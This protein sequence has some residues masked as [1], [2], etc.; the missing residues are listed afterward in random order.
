VNGGYPANTNR[1]FYLFASNAILDGFSIINGFINLNSDNTAGGGILNNGTVK[2]CII[3][4]NIVTGGNGGG[5]Y[6]GLVQ[7]CTIF[8]NSAASGGG[9]CEAT[10][11]QNCIISNNTATSHG[12]GIYGGT[13]IVSNCTVSGN[14]AGYG[15]G[16]VCAAMVQNCTIS[17]NS[18]TVV[19]GGV[20]GGTVQNSLVVGNSAG[21]GGGL[22]IYGGFVRNCII[23]SNSATISAGGVYCSGFIVFE[24]CTIIRNSAG[25]QYGGVQGGCG[26]NSIIYF[27]NCSTTSN[28]DG[29]ATNC[30]ISPLPSG[31]WGTN[32][33]ADDPQFVD[34]DA[35]DFRLKSASPC[36]NTGTNQSWMTN[37]MDI[38]GQPRIIDHIVDMGAYEYP[39]VRPSQPDNVS[40]SDGTYT[41]QVLIT[42][43]QSS[44]ALSYEV[45]RN[46]T[47]VIST[48]SKIGETSDINYSDTTAYGNQVYF[49]WVRAT[50]NSEVSA[51]S[52]YDSGWLKMF[53]P[54]VKANGSQEPVIV[55]LGDAVTVTVQMDPGDQIGLLKDWWVVAIVPGG[56]IYYF[57]SEFEWTP[58]IDLSAIHPVYQGGL[59]NLNP[60][61]VL[62]SITWLPTGSYTF[63]FAVDA[64][65]S[66]LNL[67]NIWVDSVELE[68]R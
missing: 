24:N 68:I 54:D 52:S 2:N 11:V 20:Q 37:A 31:S 46:L 60:Y 23:V 62:D 10:R 30:C 66:V 47:N 9:V 1:C 28:F 22:G 39:Y 53:G 55:N 51:F 43:S 42:W 41:N 13:V 3:T 58:A 67:D 32:N 38:Y 12:G 56:S 18:A 27:N 48:A 19:G 50:S 21:V 61:A 35:G 8:N 65:D 4:G 40:A 7:D 15:G 16:G 44:G 6:G 57:N 17:K 26:K 63:Y 36:I 29:I 25:Q 33:I 49:Y 59:F 34:V 45:Y 14:S 5:V 64:M